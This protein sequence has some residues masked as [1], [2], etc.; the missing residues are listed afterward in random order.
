VTVGGA[1]IEATA[2]QASNFRR[3]PN[4]TGTFIVRSSTSFEPASSAYVIGIRPN[5]TNIYVAGAYSLN[6]VT[7]LSAGVTINNIVI[8]IDGIYWVD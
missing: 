7:N 6:G 1:L 8:R 3:Q 5:Y 4:T 2:S